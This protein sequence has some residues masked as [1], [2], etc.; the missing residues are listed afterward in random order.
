[1]KKILLLSGFILGSIL[2]QEASAQ[3][4]I[5][6]RANI[7]SQPV[8]GPSGYDRAEYYYLPEIDVF[9]NVSRRQ[10]V[11]EQ[12]GRWVFSASLPRQYRNYDLYSGYKVVVNDNRPYRNAGMY[13]TKYAT[14][15]N[16]HNQ[17]SIRN[18]K[19]SRY[20]K[21]KEHPEHNNWQNRN[22]RRN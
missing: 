9:Y 15:K 13:R 18:S 2:F 1:M 14:Y 4:R 20:F 5:S 12:R 7:G 22:R 3:L 11:Y 10:Y 19:D 8:W 6:I 16:N 21:I 17:E